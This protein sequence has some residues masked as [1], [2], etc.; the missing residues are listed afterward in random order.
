MV[1]SFLGNGRKHHGTDAIDRLPDAQ[2]EK[3][4]QIAKAMLAP[5]TAPRMKLTV[6]GDALNIGF[7][8]GDAELAML[9]QMADMGTTDRDF[10]TGLVGQIA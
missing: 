6:K 8:S 4:T 5:E 2:R 7:A 10:H 9:F 1:R 3:V